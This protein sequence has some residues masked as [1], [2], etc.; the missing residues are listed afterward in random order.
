MTVIC[1]TCRGLNGQ[2]RPDCEHAPTV[3]VVFAKLAPQPPKPRP[4]LRPALEVSMADTVKS[5]F[6]ATRT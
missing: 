1:M 5:L 4:F 6:K 3:P 2:H